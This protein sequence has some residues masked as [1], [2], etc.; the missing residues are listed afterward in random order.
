MSVRDIADHFRSLNDKTPVKGVKKTNFKTKLKAQG[1][2]LKNTKNKNT[3]FNSIKT[4]W[5]EQ[6]DS[7]GI[8]GE[9]ESKPRL[10]PTKHLIGPNLD[11]N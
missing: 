11:G 3:T 9:I 5:E 2:T 1:D 6:T 8:F 10:R 4:Y 7:S